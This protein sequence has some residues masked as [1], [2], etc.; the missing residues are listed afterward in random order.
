MS[1]WDDASSVCESLGGHLAVIKDE[2]ENQ[3]II[4]SLLVDNGKT[5]RRN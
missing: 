4:D 5:H 2:Q 3:L 1:S